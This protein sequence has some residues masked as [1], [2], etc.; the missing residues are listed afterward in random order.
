MILQVRVHAKHLG[1]LVLEEKTE[2]Q[3]VSFLVYIIFRRCLFGD[4]YLL[5]MPKL[6]LSLLWSTAGPRF[7]AILLLPPPGYQYNKYEPPLLAFKQK[8]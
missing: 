6:V 2:N 8:V 7:R 1:A 3:K 5:N 4:T